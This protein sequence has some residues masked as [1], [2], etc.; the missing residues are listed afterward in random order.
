MK[1]ELPNGVYRV[2][3]K[4]QVTLVVNEEQVPDPNGL[5]F[6]ADYKRLY[7]VSTG[8]GP[9]DTHSGGKGEL[10]VFEVTASNTLT[11][12]KLFTDFMIDGVKARADGVR[13]DVDGNVWCSSNAGRAVGY[14]GVTVWTPDGTLIGRIRLPEVCGNL[15]FGGPKRNRLFMAASQSLY[16][17]Y[18]NT[19]GASPG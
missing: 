16:A 2:D 10:F 19:Q 17:V 13:C 9:G 5:A 18:V 1:R 11:G 14:S 12:Q 3:S 15:C 6:S 7:V 8:R 4:G